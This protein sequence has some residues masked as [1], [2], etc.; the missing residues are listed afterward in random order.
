M[1][2]LIERSFDQI[3]VI[4]LRYKKRAPRGPLLH[5]WKNNLK[6]QRKGLEI[7]CESKIRRNTPHLLLL[8]FLSLKIFERVNCEFADRHS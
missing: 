7:H 5:K 4:S 1:K 8:E 2:E 3:I 6:P